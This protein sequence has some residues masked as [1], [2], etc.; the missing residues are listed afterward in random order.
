MTTSLSPI[1]L[2]A[3]FFVARETNIRAPGLGQEKIIP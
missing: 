2:R 1:L 3:K